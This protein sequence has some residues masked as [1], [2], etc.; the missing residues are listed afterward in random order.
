[1]ID[2]YDNGSHRKHMD[3]NY[4]DGPRSFYGADG[5]TLRNRYLDLD[6]LS[7]TNIKN[8]RGT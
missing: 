1:M 3:T 2:R 5:E 6:S 7:R 4:S 8:K